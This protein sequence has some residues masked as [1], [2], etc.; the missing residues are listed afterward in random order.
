MSKKF[1]EVSVDFPS[2]EV[3]AIT[4]N[5][6]GKIIGVCSEELPDKGENEIFV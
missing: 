1:T 4:Y 2:R 5:E 6:S 3:V